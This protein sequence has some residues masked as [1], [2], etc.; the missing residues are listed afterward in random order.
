MLLLDLNVAY[1][2]GMHDPNVVGHEK[3]TFESH[4]SSRIS[5]TEIT[6]WRRR[7]SLLPALG[8]EFYTVYT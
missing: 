6:A 5:C 4:I 1:F 2:D 3:Y 8:K 7:F